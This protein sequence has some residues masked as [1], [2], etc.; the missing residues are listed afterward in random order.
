M[1]QPFR[2]GMAPALR[3]KDVAARLAVP[4]GRVLAWIKSGRL[5]AI[6][7]SEGAGCKHRWRIT[8][9][10]LAEFEATRS[11]TTTPRAR[12]RRPTSGWQFVYF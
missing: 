5:R 2:P 10:S 6:D 4:E 12:R 11:V 7:V 1:S 3:V 8:P 9:E